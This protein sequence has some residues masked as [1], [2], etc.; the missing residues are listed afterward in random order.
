[1]I[2]FGYSPEIR[3]DIY[4]LSVGQTIM[5]DDKYRISL[6]KIKREHVLFKNDRNTEFIDGDK[7]GNRLIVR[8]WQ[9]G[10][11]FTPLGMNNRR[12]LSDFFIDLKLNT[13]LKREIPIVCKDE[14]IIWIAGYRLDDKFKVTDTTTKCYKLE[15]KKNR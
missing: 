7:S 8:Y 13:T 6:N 5:V 11:K 9:K 1:V 12:K 4:H 2:V 3:E 10:D 15:L 14:Q